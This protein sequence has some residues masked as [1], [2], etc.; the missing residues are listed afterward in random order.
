MATG[1]DGTSV[2]REGEGVHRVVRSKAKVSDILVVG[3]RRGLVFRDTVRS[4]VASSATTS[5]GGRAWGSKD[6][7]KVVQ[8]E[9]K[10]LCVSKSKQRSG[11]NRKET[12][13][14]YYVF[15]GGCDAKEVGLKNCVN[16]SATTWKR[17]VVRPRVLSGEVWS[18]LVR[19]RHD[20]Q[21][22]WLR[23]RD[24]TELGTWRDH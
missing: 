7:L 16:V 15:R 18:G 24:Q 17:G 14:Y 20:F 13:R 9:E 2:R 22:C 12:K 10:V 23:G 3:A 19:Q 21:C 5:G 1:S 6:V 11:E 4:R 8:K